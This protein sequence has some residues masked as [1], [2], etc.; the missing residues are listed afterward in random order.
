MR[1]TGPVT[2]KEVDLDKSDELVSATDAKGVI[3]FVNETFCKIAK[4]ER[5]ELLGQA[6][7][8][9][10]HP[11]MPEEAFKLLWETIK[12]GKPWLGAVKN[13]CKDGDHYWVSAHVTPTLENGK[14]VGFES[15]R[16][17]PEPQ[18]VR[19]A[20]LTYKRIRE[21]QAAIP[22]ALVLWQKLQDLAFYFLVLCTFGFLLAGFLEGL[23]AITS[24]IVVV[25]S[26]LAAL[27]IWRFTYKKYQNMATTARQIIDDPLATYIYTGRTD[28]EG[29]VLFSQ[30]A[31]TQ[32]LGTALGRFG[33]SAKEVLRTAEKVQS[34]SKNTYQRM[35]KQQEDTQGIASAIQQMSHAVKEVATSASTT[36]GTT[37]QT[38]QQLREGNAIVEGA[39]GVIH[40]MSKSISDL[41]VVVEQLKGDGDRI[42]SVVGVIRGIAEQTNLLAL[43]AAIEAARAGEQG[44]GFAVVADEVRTLAQRTQESTT[45]IQ[46]IIE[47]LGTATESAAGK[48]QSC[49]SMVNRSVEEVSNVGGVLL[50]ITDAVNKIDALSQQIAVAAEEQ[51]DAASNIDHSSKAISNTTDQSRNESAHT[52]EIGAELSDLAQKQFD[53]ISRFK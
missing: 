26:F 32:H 24:L 40:S 4:Y 19:R 17:K 43:N 31:Q 39:G 2:G 30:M 13:R 28:T 3:T 16:C 12:Q 15:V 8:L 29:L 49:L 42:S 52:A 35:I 45:D 22:R 14:V 44:R 48:M 51:S 38:V 6:H 37:K 33:E 11:D 27:S 9:V 7:N 21:G 20:E 18:V 34:Q 41:S 23:N 1:N 53:L 50:E 46:E 36:S 5:D 10:R 25:S 47:A